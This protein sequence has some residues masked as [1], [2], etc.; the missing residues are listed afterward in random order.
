[1]APEVRFFAE[2]YASLSRDHNLP[3]QRL[4]CAAKDFWRGIICCSGPWPARLQDRATELVRRLVEQGAL[5][6]ERHPMD[7][8]AAARLCDDLRLFTEQ[9]LHGG[10]EHPGTDT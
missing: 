2:C 4:R 8:V 10:L 7:P 3:D 9:F 5:G 1:M 6:S